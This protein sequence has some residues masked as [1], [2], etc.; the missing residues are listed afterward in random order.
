MQNVSLLFG[1]FSDTKEKERK[2]K[3]NIEIKQAASRVLVVVVKRWFLF[4]NLNLYCGR[5]HTSMKVDD[6]HTYTHTVKP[7]QKT[8]VDRARDYGL[9]SC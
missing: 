7:G 2:K 8:S 3:R 5:M 4:H 1:V 9:C 6:T